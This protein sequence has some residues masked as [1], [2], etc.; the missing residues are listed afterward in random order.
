ME[1][2]KI[3]NLYT[4]NIFDVSLYLYRINSIFS[5][6]KAAKVGYPLQQ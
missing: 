2:K 4:I 5:V 6:K 1:S 3:A